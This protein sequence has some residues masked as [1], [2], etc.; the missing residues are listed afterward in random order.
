MVGQA[1]PKRKYDPVSAAPVKSFFVTMLT[2]DIT[3]P[4]AI[5]D[6]LDNCIDGIHRSSKQLPSEKPYSGFYAEIEFNKDSFSIHDNCGGIPWELHDFA[7][8]MGRPKERIDERNGTVGTY[9][10][11]MKRALFKIGQECLIV[12]KNKTDSYE[13]EIT[14]DWLDD[15]TNWHIPV[16]KAK[17]PLNDDGT[18]I[19]V[20]KLHPGVSSLFGPD[21]K[22]FERDFFEDVSSH[23]AFIIEKGFEIKVNGTTVPGKP[24]E[25]IFDTNS[26]KTKSIRPYI[27]EGEYEGVEI[28]LTVGFTQPIP[29]VS[30]VIDEQE[31]R[32]Y[33]T[34]AAGWTVLCNDRAVLYCDRTEKTGW[35]VSGLPRYHTQF[36]AISGIVEFRSSDP[37]K[38]PTT[39]TKRGIDGSST[40][41]LKIKDRM[42]EGLRIFID[43]TNNW[44]GD[45]ETAKK[46]MKEGTKMSFH[47]LKAKFNELPA[48]QVRKGI[49]GK[50]YKPTLP[51]P[52][53]TEPTHQKITFTRPTE[54][55]R[56]LGKYLLGDEDASPSKIG[57]KS[58]I[59]VLRGAKK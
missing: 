48:N 52:P 26:D 16:R 53:K 55:I 22:S 42:Q 40:L 33:S 6:L 20:G 36:I 19:V 43:Y 8:R 17:K 1:N 10:I 11:G 9:G 51:E 49:P 44:K 13:V 31:Q 54:E 46:H 25:L 18:T 14:S 23:Y 38:L 3:L 21:Q 5:L 45:A 4:E 50:H 12:T 59:E 58:F 35:G 37:S 57:E 56:I 7:F 15:E 27:F 28:F 29:S 32:K 2:R 34:L 39:T 41:Y 24:T 47:E 30:D